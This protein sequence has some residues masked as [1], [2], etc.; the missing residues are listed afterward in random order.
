MM[1]LAVKITLQIA[2]ELGRQGPS[3]E[4]ARA[5]LAAA[6]AQVDAA[7]AGRQ[8][9]VGAELRAAAAPGS[10]VRIPDTDIYVS[11]Q[12]SIDGVSLQSRVGLTVSIEQPIADFGQTRARIEAARRARDAAALETRASAA[13][14]DRAVADAFF[15]WAAA[16]A[17]ASAARADVE[18]AATAARE[19]R[20]LLAAG[21]QTAAGV[22]DATAAEA[23]ASLA[24]SRVIADAAASRFALEGLVGPLPDGATPEVAAMP[25][26]RSPDTTGARSADDVERDALL[27]RAGAARAEAEA[28]SFARRPQLSAELALGVRAIDDRVFPGWE[29]ALVLKM[30]LWDPDRAAAER[31]ARARARGLAAQAEVSA[32]ARQAEQRAASSASSASSQRVMLAA[33][34]VEHARRTVERATTRAS[35]GG[36]AGAVEQARAALRAAELEHRLAVIDEASARFLERGAAR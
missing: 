13:D 27:A 5:N 32:R 26:V 23:R 31:T 6:S 20:A 11:G 29:G 15:R 12:E 30:P 9:R 2:L 1:S 22:D 36:D 3:A 21:K 34:L 10:L 33:S 8:P 35:V 16:D 14:R 18:A 17:L 7:R 24:A 19:A 4:V 25:A 28:L